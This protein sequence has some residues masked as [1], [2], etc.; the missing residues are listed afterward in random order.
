MASKVKSLKGGTLVSQY[1]RDLHLLA[2]NVGTISVVVLWKD[3]PAPVSMTLCES[4]GWIP[5]FLRALYPALK[6]L[7][8][9][10]VP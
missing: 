2:V 8:A 4:L 6:F 5:F 3:L 10:C 7:A 1:A 9:V